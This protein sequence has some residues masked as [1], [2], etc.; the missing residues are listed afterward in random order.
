MTVGA[1]GLVFMALIAPEQW[2]SAF[3]WV[4]IKFMFL[5]ATLRVLYLTSPHQGKI[6]EFWTKLLETYKG[7]STEQKLYVNACILM[8]GLALLL[9]AGGKP[10]LLAYIILLTFFF[11]YI[12]LHDVFRWYK[13]LSENLL[14]KAII[15][16]AFAAATNLAYSLAGQE[17]TQIVHVTPTNFVRTTLFIAILMIPV[18]MIFAGGI[19]FFIG[20]F[21]SS[22]VMLP[23]LL[24]NFDPRLRSWLFAGTLAV[25]PLRFKFITRLFQIIFYSTIGYTIFASGQ[26]GLAWY[27]SKISYLAPRL[28][29]YFDMYEGQECKLGPQYKLAPLGDA[30]FLLAQKLPSGIINF[31]P[32][33]KCDDLP[34][35]GARAR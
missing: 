15:G 23:S 14:G 5:G 17:V 24:A 31:E 2:R 26:N 9:L 1:F 4:T 30:K 29:Y 7:L 18:L 13:A 11:G 8:L 20:I 3:V 10:F 21:M 19:I 16:I 33:V 12:A 6:D 25:S 28:I 34:P 22:I 32:P 35:N 27:E